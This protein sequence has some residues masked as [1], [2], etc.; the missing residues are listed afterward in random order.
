MKNT[1]FPTP[2]NI[3]VPQ[4]PSK[5]QDMVNEAGHHAFANHA[6][7]M[8]NTVRNVYTLREG[9]FRYKGPAYEQPSSINNTSAT[10]A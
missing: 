7:V 3:T 2:S 8:S 10:A 9:D 5:L 1:D 4:E 6:K